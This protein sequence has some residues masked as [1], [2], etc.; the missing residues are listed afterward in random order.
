[1]SVEV[2]LPLI[3]LQAEFRLHTLATPKRGEKTSQQVVRARLRTTQFARPAA[4]S[5]LG[6]LACD[7]PHSTIVKRASRC[8]GGF[9]LYQ[10]KANSIS[11][12]RNG[13]CSDPYRS[14]SL[15]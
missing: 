1:M 14:S 11:H 5:F 6:F 7:G 13:S 8:A 15:A 3:A 10:T 4:R 12:R 2:S 9:T